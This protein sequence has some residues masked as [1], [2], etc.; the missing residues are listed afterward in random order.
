MV[1]PRCYE[2]LYNNKNLTDAECRNWFIHI[3]VIIQYLYYNIISSLF[4]LLGRINEEVMK[5][6]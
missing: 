6:F 2:T 5:T 4:K 3:G 1:H